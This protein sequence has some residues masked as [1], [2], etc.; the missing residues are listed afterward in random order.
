MRRSGYFVSRY[1]G[2]TNN[3]CSKIPTTRTSHSERVRST[4]N[5]VSIFGYN[6]NEVVL[7]ISERIGTAMSMIGLAKDMTNV[8]S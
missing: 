5:E 3:E 1:T 6:L 7:E 4:P 8:D 2:F